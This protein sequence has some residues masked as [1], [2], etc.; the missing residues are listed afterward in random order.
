MNLKTC[1]DLDR[2]VITDTLIAR[3]ELV[4]AVK[5]GRVVSGENMSKLVSDF[6]PTFFA[7]I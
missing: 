7:V 4:D 1:I 5:P 6:F 2:V 3:S